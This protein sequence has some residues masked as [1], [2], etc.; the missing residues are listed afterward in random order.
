MYYG[1]FDQ[2]LGQFVLAV[3]TSQDGFK[4]DKLGRVFAGQGPGSFDAFGVTHV[5][6]RKLEGQENYVM[7]YEGKGE[8]GRS[9][10]GLATSPDG[11]GWQPANRGKPVFEPLPSEAWEAA[12]VGAPR[13][14]EMGDGSLRMY[15]EGTSAEGVGTLGVAVASAGDLS[16]WTRLE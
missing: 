15:Y 7:L 9:C 8:G 12:G 3:A 14:V 1:T 6:V 13:I 11:I 2:A 10:I 16:K 5:H 4:W